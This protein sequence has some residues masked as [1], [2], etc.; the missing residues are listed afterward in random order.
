[1]CEFPDPGSLA[2]VVNAWHICQ[3][4]FQ[5]FGVL[6]ADIVASQVAPEAQH[7]DA[8]AIVATT[9]KRRIYDPRFFP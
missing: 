8:G 1:M 2:I 4:Q 7:G 5:A 9:L 3:E 6:C